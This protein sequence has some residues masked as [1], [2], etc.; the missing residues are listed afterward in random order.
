M[1]VRDTDRDTDLDWKTIAESDPFWGVLS[2]EDYRQQYEERTTGA[3][4]QYRGAYWS[5]SCEI[6]GCTWTRTS[7]QIDL[8]ISAAGWDVC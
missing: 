4:L 1:V 5:T 8:W 3:F 6:Y 2:V 7:H